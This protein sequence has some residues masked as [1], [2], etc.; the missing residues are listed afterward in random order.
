MNEK[1]KKSRIFSSLIKSQRV[2]VCVF[3]KKKLVVIH[4]KHLRMFSAFF[5]ISSHLK[6]IS[7]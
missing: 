6:Q 2:C 4:G 7:P 3:F 1:K 5:D